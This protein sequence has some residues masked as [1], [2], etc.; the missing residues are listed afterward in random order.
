ML[1]SNYLMLVNQTTGLQYTRFLKICLK[2][3]Q[4]SI[5]EELITDGEICKNIDVSQFNRN[6][7]SNSERN[8]VE[9]NAKTGG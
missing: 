4:L 3:E 6:F 5:S 2:N 8:A 9:I 7:V 1:S